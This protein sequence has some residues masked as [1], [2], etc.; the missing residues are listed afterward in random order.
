MVK[1]PPETTLLT[2]EPEMSPFKPDDTT[3]TL[4]GPPRKW[5]RKAKLTC[6]M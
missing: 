2:E 1:M 6:I 5:P 3:D 4:A